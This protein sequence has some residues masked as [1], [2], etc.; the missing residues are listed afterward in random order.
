MRLKN[1]VAF[2]SGSASG[3]GRGIAERFAR[4]GAVVIINDIKPEQV[5]LAVEE[6]TSNNGKAFGVVADVS[7]SR[8]VD[9]AFDTI[10]KE[11]GGLDI[12]VNNVG[13]IRDNFIM[14]MTDE[15]W[16]AVIKV[17]LRSYFLCSRAA[18]KIM[19]EQHFGR[20]V[21]ISSRAW[22][23]GIGQVNYAASKGGIV[24]LTRTLALELAKSGVTVNCIAPGI[25]DT[26]MFRSIS[27]K[28][29]QRQL[30]MQPMA[31]VGS[32]GDIAYA[33]LNFADEEAWYIT[34][35]VL[36]VC[37]GKSLANYIG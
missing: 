13:I 21:N 8:Q 31:K 1:R 37:G 2:I 20:I 36:Y 29:K 32:P 30:N 3:I 22:L 35:Q 24:S 15:D 17:N 33:C 11:Y 10:K 19:T 5:N 12:L 27:D 23:G 16:D 9:A 14:K 34:G 26:P 18:A 4:E 6:I 7:D 25:I 28:A